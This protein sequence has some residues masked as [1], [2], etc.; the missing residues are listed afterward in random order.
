LAG[1]ESLSYYGQAMRGHLALM[2]SRES[3]EVLLRDPTL[4][5]M[6]RERLETL[7]QMR[8]FAEANLALPVGN[9]YADLVRQQSPYV[10][11]NVFAAPEFS[12]APKRWCYPVAGCAAYR[13]YFRR[14]AAQ[15]YADVLRAEGW[16]VYVGGVSAYST[17]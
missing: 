1:C 8:S 11:W 16:D 14:D 9:N 15:G 7:E 2:R 10:V 13:G 3:I 17:L 6:L 4:D 12:L 5:P